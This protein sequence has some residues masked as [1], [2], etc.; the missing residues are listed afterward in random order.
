M[1]LCFWSCCCCFFFLLLLL[2]P[3][4]TWMYREK[5]EIP[6]LVTFDKWK[7]KKL[8]SNQGNFVSIK[9]NWDSKLHERYNNYEWRKR[10]LIDFVWSNSVANVE[11][12][13]RKNRFTLWICVIVSKSSSANPIKFNY[14]LSLCFRLT[15]F[16]TVHSYTMT[17]ELC[18]CAFMGLSIV[19]LWMPA[20][21]FLSLSK[22]FHALWMLLRINKTIV[23][24]WMRASRLNLLNIKCLIHAMHR[25]K[26]RK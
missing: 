1:L 3:P 25:L 12:M 7:K 14:W 18:Y 11:E 17:L 22:K 8:F 21:Y 2:L 16:E 23:S 10:L 15:A 4:L 26:I 13:L 24:N 20:N 6:T 19:V 5:Y 9:S